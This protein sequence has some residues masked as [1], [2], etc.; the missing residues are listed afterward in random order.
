MLNCSIKGEGY[1]IVF[2]H[3]FLESISMWQYLPLEELKCQCILVD[4]PGHG[5]SDLCERLP[6]SIQSMA[7]LVLELIDHL[8]I[9]KFSVVGHSMGGYVGLELKNL[10]ARAEKIVLLN[11]NPWSDS[12]QKAVDRQRVARIVYKAKDLFL[13][14]AIPNLFLNPVSYRDEI[15]ILIGEAA[16][17]EADAIAYASLAMSTR[18]DHT[19]LVISDLKV[20]F[21]IQGEGDKI[22]PREDMDALMENLPNYFVI[23]HAGH[24]THI[25]QTAGVI[26]CLSVIFKQ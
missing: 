9:D 24:M 5:E 11:S 18:K 20:F 22:V 16:S 2:L 21:V 17:M 14:E 8:G 19:A 6:P 23:P 15:D 4:L 13:K 26:R 25:E 7:E 10:S 1:P 12:P 3:G